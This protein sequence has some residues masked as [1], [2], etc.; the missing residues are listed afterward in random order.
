L[1]AA[2]R[3]LQ[4]GE[5]G[6]HLGELAAGGRT[7][8]GERIAGVPEIID[9]DTHQLMAL[10]GIRGDR[11]RVLE[12]AQVALGGDVHFQERRVVVRKLAS[13][14]RVTL[15]LGANVPLELPLATPFAAAQA[16]ALP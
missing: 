1:V 15:A 13:C 4:H 6:G 10:G 12:L 8:R 16:T 5:A 14:W 9:A 7:L 3:R 2:G 11:G